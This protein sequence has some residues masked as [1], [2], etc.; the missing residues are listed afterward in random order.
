MLEIIGLVLLC[1]VNSKNAAARGQS[2]GKY[3]AFTILLW[4]GMEFL[5]ALIGGL[6]GL[7]AGAY[8]LALLF[9]AGGAVASYFI[10]K[11]KRGAAQANYAQGAAAGYAPYGY[12]AQNAQ[13]PS[14]SVPQPYAAAAPAVAAQPP[15]DTP[16]FCTA[17]GYVR[18]PGAKF[19]ERCG[20]PLPEAPAVATMQPPV[21]AAAP[22]PAQSGVSRAEL[23]SAA[24]AVFNSPFSPMVF[25]PDDVLWKEPV[26]AELD[27]LMRGGAES[28]SVIEE[29]LMQ[30]ARGG[31]AAISESWWY[32]GKWALKSA[33]IL[34]RKEAAAMFVRLLQTN[35]NIAE[36]FTAIQRE[37]AIQLGEIGDANSLPA[38]KALLTNPFSM[39]PTDAV[40]KAIK[41]IEDEQAIRAEPVAAD[42]C[43]QQVLSPDEMTASQ[44]VDFMATDEGMKSGL[45]LLG[46]KLSA[47]LKEGFYDRPE[48]VEKAIRTFGDEAMVARFNMIRNTMQPDDLGLLLPDLLTQYIARRGQ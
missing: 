18:K 15:A 34:P 9:A 16:K 44:L 26:Q 20:A 17:C 10:A 42:V 47:K 41:K 46:M 22:A 28:V 31:G 24:H 25:D 14:R 13:Y 29:L 45:G 23:V 6:A 30:C 21:A 11:G 7:G 39:T 27:T 4:V 33:A 35:S 19:C 38:L 43:E 1:N 8:I 37:A 36:W 40:E 2:G 3:V 48:D 12:G 5:G 32:G